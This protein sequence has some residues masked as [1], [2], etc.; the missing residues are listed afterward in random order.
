MTFS[1][2]I[3]TR[4][5][6]EEL[7]NTITKVKSQKNVTLE[8][9]VV[10]NCSTDGT[11]SMLK[12]IHP[13]V[14]VCALDDNMGTVARNYG[15]KLATSEIIIF[16][17]DDVF[18][19]SDNEFSLLHECFN[20]EPFPSCIA[21]KV[22]SAQTGELETRSWGH[23]FN[24]ESY[25]TTKFETDCITEG[26][27][28]FLKDH[29]LNVGGYFAPL[30]IGEEGADLALNLIKN[31][32]K[33][34]YDPSIKVFHS[35]SATGR[36]SWRSYYYYARNDIWIAWRNL[37]FIEALKFL[38]RGIGMLVVSGIRH[39]MFKYVIKGIVDAL[40]G[41]KNNR[42]KRDP[43]SSEA[44]QYLKKIRSKR[45]SIWFSIKKHLKQREL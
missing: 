11:Q 33:I 25:C 30:F 27:S 4:N 12:S 14:V 17:D 8:I 45:H 7:L 35:H 32:Y 24:Y 38:T 18:P 13:D 6:K 41:F 43:L 19:V 10:D 44:L 5:R 42:I 40:S 34:V 3:L 22:L 37:P 20:C 36:V 31:N 15:A 29:F 28:A 26:A 2:I 39:G 16:L 21:F 23:P 9:I 1:V